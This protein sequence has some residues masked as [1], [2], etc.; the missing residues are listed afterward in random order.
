MLDHGRKRPPLQYGLT[1]LNNLFRGA[2]SNRLR[3]AYGRDK[4]PIS[5]RSYVSKLTGAQAQ[6]LIEERNLKTV[7]DSWHYSWDL[8]RF[9]PDLYLYETHLHSYV[10]HDRPISY[11]SAPAPLF[12]DDPTLTYIIARKGRFF[13]FWFLKYGAFDD[14][15]DRRSLISSKPTSNFPTRQTYRRL[16]R[17]KGVSIQRLS[18]LA[19]REL[20]IEQFSRWKAERFHFDGTEC[21]RFYLSVNPHVPLEWFHFYLLTNPETGA[22]RGVVLTI[23]DGR[24]AT[25]LNL[26]NET[27]YGLLMIVEALRLMADLKYSSINAGVSGTYGHFKNVLFLDT[28][29]TDATGLPPI[30]ADYL[31]ADSL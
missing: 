2:S 24:S 27:G 18:L 9:F 12:S 26:A 7:K 28:I 20:F 17:R 25:M 29:K 22:G 5:D 15:L 21:V 14:F 6:R 11:V 10:F 1:T 3:L 4:R 13:P 31:T 19:N 8:E 23:E 30:G 16:F